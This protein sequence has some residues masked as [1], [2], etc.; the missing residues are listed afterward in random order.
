LVPDL[1]PDIP[2]FGKVRTQEMVMYQCFGRPFRYRNL[3]VLK[4]QRTR[5]QAVSS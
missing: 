5:I 4:M 2:R 1:N 3:L